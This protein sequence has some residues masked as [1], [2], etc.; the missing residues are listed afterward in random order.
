MITIWD[1]V[2][3]QI[4]LAGRRGL[5]RPSCVDNVGLRGLED[6]VSED[7]FKLVHDAHLEILV[8]QRSTASTIYKCN[9]NAWHSTSFLGKGG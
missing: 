4:L 2:D 8:A 7:V 9:R 6:K 1:P 3:D 5:T